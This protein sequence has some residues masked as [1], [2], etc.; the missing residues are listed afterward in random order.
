[1]SDDWIA[2]PYRYPLDVSLATKLVL[3]K[4]S[5]TSAWHDA[6]VIAFRST[7]TDLMVPGS[8]LIG[9]SEDS[10]EKTPAYRTGDEGW[11]LCWRHVG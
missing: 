2:H 5:P 11:Q 7:A 4:E 3:T 1:V 10:G 9:S 6:G 8:V